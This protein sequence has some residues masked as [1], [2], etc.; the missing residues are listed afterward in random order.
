MI[1]ALLPVI[2]L[3]AVAPAA[4]PAQALAGRY[5]RQFSDKLVGGPYYRGEDIVEIV[6]V[7]ADAAYFRIHLDYANGHVCGIYGV[8][9]ATGDRLVYRDPAHWGSNRSCRLTIR[10]DGKRLRIDDG[11]QSC[12]A[13]CGARGTLSEVSLPFASRRKIRYMKRLKASHEY[14]VSLAEWRTGKPKMDFWKAS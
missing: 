2:A 8:A 14:R 1:R 11:E 9:Q 3:G 7:A 13:Y 6:P 10:R 4:S 5:Y 12:S